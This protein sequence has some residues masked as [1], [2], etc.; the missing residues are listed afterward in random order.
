MKDIF[1]ENFHASCLPWE[2]HKNYNIRLREFFIFLNQVESA[3][4]FYGKH[5]S[6]NFLTHLGD[7]DWSPKMEMDL[8]ESSAQK[9]LNFFWFIYSDWDWS[10]SYL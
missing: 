2:M 9:C 8:S 3:S 4:F 1:F 10:V 5:S 6:G 7:L